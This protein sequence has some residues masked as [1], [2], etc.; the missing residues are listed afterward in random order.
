MDLTKGN[1]SRQ[2]I[3][4]ALPIVIMNLLNQAYAI[5]DSVIVSRF[6]GEREL[7]IVSATMAVLAVGYCL[8]NGAGSAC[9]IMI[10]NQFGQKNYDKIKSTMKTITYVGIVFSVLLAAVY[11]ISGPYFFR[12][13]ELPDEL[14]D[15]CVLLLNVYAVSFIVQVI[16]M[17]QSS[18]LNGI[19]DSKTPMLIG[20]CTQ[21]LNIVLDIIVV[22][23]MDGGAMGA[24]FASIFSLCVSVVWTFWIM[25]KK[26]NALSAYKGDF[27]KE[28]L[29]QYIRLTIP[30]LLQQ[31]VMS[32]GSLFLQRLVNVQGIEAINGYTV[33]ININGFFL[34][35]VIAYTAAFE[36]FASQNLGAEDEVRTKQGFRCMMWQGMLLCAMLGLGTLLFVKPLIGLY[37]NDTSSYGY[38]FAYQYSVILIV[39]FFALLLKYGVDALFKA[40]MKIYLFTISSLIA[41]VFRIALAYMLVGRMGLIALA[42]ATIAGN[43]IAIAFNW[44]VKAYLKY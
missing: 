23:G 39:N 20:L 15:D 30:S 32:V 14:L 5:A 3:K 8:V 34:I 26:L 21:V 35:P 37:L 9:H 22:A 16:C 28:L 33:A 6:A 41:L 27:D 42:V 19:G 17:I 2:M 4:F 44:G 29:K 13:V 24:A 40:H 7:S 1:I 38:Q 36:T 43:A 12:I 10:G 18:V 25:R 31:S 11:I